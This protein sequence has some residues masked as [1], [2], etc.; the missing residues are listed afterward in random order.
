MMAKCCDNCQFIIRDCDVDGFIKCDYYIVDGGD[1]EKEL[2]LT[3]NSMCAS[4]V[5]A[6]T[7]VLGNE[8]FD[9]KLRADN[10]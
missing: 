2:I 4:W 3:K 1:C 5:L 10:D 8:V 6:K 7:I 9:I